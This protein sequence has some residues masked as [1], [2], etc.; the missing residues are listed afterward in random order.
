MAARS[1][2]NQSLSRLHHNPDFQHLLKVLGDNEQSLLDELAETVD[3]TDAVLRLRNWQFYRRFLLDMKVIPEG[4]ADSFSMLADDLDSET[5][6]GEGL[7]PAFMHGMR[8]LG[9]F[10]DTEL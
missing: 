2:L 1:E 10:D 7:D 4:A 3:D 6:I 5:E 9:M 8:Q